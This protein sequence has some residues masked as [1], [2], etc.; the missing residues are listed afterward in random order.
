MQ[1]FETILEYNEYIKSNICN[2]AYIRSTGQVFINGRDINSVEDMSYIYI[3]TKVNVVYDSGRDFFVQKGLNI[4]YNFNTNIAIIE[5]PTSEITSIINSMPDTVKKHVIKIIFG[6]NINDF[7]K[8]FINF[9]SLTEIINIPNIITRINPRMFYNCH[10]LEKINLPNTITVIG[11]NA[12]R[13]CYRLDNIN[14]PGSVEYIGERVFWNCKS[15]VSIVIPNSVQSIGVNCF[16]CCRDLET[17]KLNPNIT[18][19]P[20]SCFSNCHSLENVIW[21]PNSMF[22]EID[23]S[24]FNKCTMLKNIESWSNNISH[25]GLNAFYESSYHDTYMDYFRDDCQVDGFLNETNEEE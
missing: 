10:N 5:I 6:K 12:F 17:I 21:Q 18:I 13:N 25:V 15:L 11:E 4:K 20:V 9:T 16:G 2:I 19:I 1:S 3:S 7:P 8:D 24:A 22:A 23:D 14:I